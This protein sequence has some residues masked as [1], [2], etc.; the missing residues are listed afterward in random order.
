VIKIEYAASW[1]SRRRFYSFSHRLY[2]SDTRWEEPAVWQGRRVLLPAY[3]ELLRF[4]HAFLTATENGRILARML[5]GYNG[6]K[7][8]FALFDACSRED[9]VRKMFDEAVVW[10]KE[11]GATS[12]CGPVAPTMIDL[13]GGILRKGFE[14]VAPF[15]DAYNAEYYGDYLERY[16]FGIESEWLA[17]R[18]DLT[19]FDR[20]K[21]RDISERLK[22][23]SG[24]NVDNGLAE[25]PRKLAEVL[26]HVM[27]GEIDCESA[28]RLIGRLHPFVCP[29]LCPVAM[30][31]GDPIGFLLTIRKNAAR[32]RI[33]NLW[34]KQRFR[35]RGI[36][37]LLFDSFAREADLLG[38]MEADASM[39]S[40][41]NLASR[42]G[43]EL[44]GGEVTHYYCRYKMQI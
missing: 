24:Y 13:G 20:K 35:R 29:A 8:Y 32:P 39:V 4:P 30:L 16:G 1:L 38:V 11:Q 25:N 9:A 15:N 14:A 10:L 12:L 7:G 26:C 33:V 43:V 2:R 37:A 18:V 6:Q 36:T 41:D 28:N 34:V 5:M 22:K 31:G 21:Y 23:R 27:E 44:A 17:Y 3:N 42:L 19:A 40:K